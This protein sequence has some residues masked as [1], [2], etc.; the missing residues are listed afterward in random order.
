MFITLAL[1]G[2]AVALDAGSRYLLTK[3]AEEP[4]TP[5]DLASAVRNEADA[6]QAALIEYM[7]GTT[8]SAPGIA[9]YAERL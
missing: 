7:N 1:I 9:T 5:P 2:V 8:V 4:A 3:L 6:E